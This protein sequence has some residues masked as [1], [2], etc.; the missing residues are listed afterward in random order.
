MAAHLLDQPR[1][2]SALLLG[3]IA[4][5]AVFVN[6]AK[7]LCDA[8]HVNISP[9]E[10]EI[11]MEEKKIDL[12]FGSLSSRNE[13]LYLPALKRVRERDARVKIILFLQTD[14]LSL[15]DDI[16]ALKCERYLSMKHESEAVLDHFKE[17]IKT[18]LD[19]SYLAER[20]YFQTLIDFSIVSQTDIDG[21]ITYMN[22]NFLK[23]T[24]Y[25]R[26]ELM[27]HDHQR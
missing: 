1:L 22:D 13:H 3:E 14:Q 8:L 19:D 20:H 23:V 24:G 26:E 4:Y 12:I 21:N 25:E 16:L 9:C 18:F 15:L 6:A 7:K 17:C 2:I 5:D 27:G 10:I 11:M